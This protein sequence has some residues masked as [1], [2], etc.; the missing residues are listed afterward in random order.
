[1]MD[2]EKEDWAEELQKIASKI[3]ELASDLTDDKYSQ[4]IPKIIQG[5][6]FCA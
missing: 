3:D 6:R 4:A 1:M 5:L 2:S